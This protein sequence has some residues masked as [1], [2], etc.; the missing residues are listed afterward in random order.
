MDRSVGYFA[1]ESALI[2]FSILAALGVNEWRMRAA[3]SADERQAYAAVHAEL[4]DNLELLD[5]LPQYH[6]EVAAALRAK[7]TDFAANPPAEGATPMDVFTSLEI[8]HPAIII[9]RLPQDVSW[10]LAKSRGAAARFDYET[11]RALSIIYDG[12]QDGVLPLIDDIAALLARPE[13]F[14]ARDHAAALAPIAAQF[15]ELA[16]REETLVAY[17][18]KEIAAMEARRR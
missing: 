13:M 8:L 16:S 7:I 17:L 1:R 14:L 15:A 2:V 12:Q 4:A 18:E 5:G 10:E 3:A 11:A 9:D 6:A